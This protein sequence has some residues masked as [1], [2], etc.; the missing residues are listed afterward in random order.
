MKD[1]LRDNHDT[2]QKKRA[3]RRQALGLFRGLAHSGVLEMRDRQLR[4]A[5]AFAQEFSLNQALSLYVLEVVAS[6]DQTERE[7]SLLVVSLI[8]AVA[9]DPGIVLLRQQDVMKTR[10]MAELKHAGVEYDERI[11]ELEKVTHLIPPERDF[12]DGTFEAFSKQHRWAISYQISP[13]SVARDMYEQG[14]A[15]NGYIKEYGLERAE[16]VLLRYL[17]DVFR[18]LERS[19]PESAK[20]EELR[21]YID[22]L[23]A[24]VRAVDASLLEEWARLQNPEAALSK[25]EPER[26]EE[27][28][29]TRDR[30]AF[31]V[32]LRNALWRLLTAL[33]HKDY[34]RAARELE[35]GP[36]GS[37]DAAALEAAL[38]PYFEEYQALRLDPVARS[39]RYLTVTDEG[40]GLRLLQTLVD[41]E[42][43]LG[44]SL[45]CT[46]SIE[47][48]RV[49]GRPV[50]VLNELHRG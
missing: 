27:F 40:S 21:D 24:E 31:T 48:S 5:G 12:L 34:E 35:A 42:E 45:E 26:P 37:W 36:S 14:L 20:T 19:L 18:L 3:Q 23:G 46:V 16:G 38:G 15:F 8:E 41:P 43:D 25:K 17:S 13:K 7:Y 49:A 22:W 6:L 4:V 10:R 47:A 44:W 33:G 29:V 30:R 32:L 50:L 9:E 28:D 11:A 2:E 39:P 1:L